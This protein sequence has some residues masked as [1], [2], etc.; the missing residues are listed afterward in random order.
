[1]SQQGERIVLT[2][3]GLLTFAAGAGIVNW[4]RL[5]GFS[6]DFWN[7]KE[8]AEWSSQEIEQLTTKSPWA[9]ETSAQYSRDASDQNGGGYPGGGGGY[10]GGGGGGYPGGGGGG[11]PGGGG[12]MGGGRIGGM[13]MPG[14]MGGGG[15]GGRGRGGQQAQSVRGT[16][17]WESAKPILEAMKTPLPDAFANRYVISLSGFP[18]NGGH[19]RRSQDDSDS[20]SS[21]TSSQSIEDKLDRI[22]S[23]TFL[24]PKGRDGAQPGIVQQSPG[25]G[26]GN[27]LFGFSKEILAL[28]ADDREVTFSTKLGGLLV[29]TKF[30]LKEMMYRGDLAL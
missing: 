21:D 7:K 13:G 19:S 15:R 24:E 2:R 30:N 1:M 5:Y 12:G 17:R 18:L 16:V 8:P 20:N 3:R 11:Y 4:G 26:G 14:G 6:S 9:K 23:L 28:K 29:R 25:V 22:K 10:P 27:I